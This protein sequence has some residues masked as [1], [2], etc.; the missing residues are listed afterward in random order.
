MRSIDGR[1]ACN[2]QN[3]LDH[4]QHNPLNEKHLT[5]IAVGVLCLG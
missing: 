5:A 1:Y 4:A 2:A 3:A